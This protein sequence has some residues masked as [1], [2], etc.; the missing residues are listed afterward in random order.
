MSIIEKEIKRLIREAI[1]LDLAK[2]SLGI[3][4][5]VKQNLLKSLEDYE[6]LNKA[7]I[8]EEMAQQTNVPT[9]IPDDPEFHAAL[10]NTPGM[11]LSKEG[12]HATINRRQKPEQGGERTVRSGIFYLPGEENKIYTGKLGYGGTEKIIG[13]T[14]IKNPIVGRGGIGGSQFRKNVY[15]KIHG[16]GSW[17]REE[18]HVK[19]LFWRSPHN[20]DRKEELM[21]YLH[22]RHGIDRE[23]YKNIEENSSSGT[24]QKFTAILDTMVGNAAKRAGHDA[25]I[26]H[27]KGKIREIYDLRESTY[28]IHGHSGTM[29]EQYTKSEMADLNKSMNEAERIGTQIGIDWDKAEFT[30]Q[31]LAD[32]MKV[33]LEHGSKDPQ[34]NITDDDPI[35]TAKVALAHL[36]ENKDYYQKL[37]QVESDQTTA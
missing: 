34:T 3:K 23:Q 24:N 31:D 16:E 2:S 13:H 4:E 25:I 5:Y 33:E 19:L 26:T 17:D 22:H 37:K 20:P 35:K 14:L 10:Q 21:D 12:I 6:A 9:N 28:P 8:T 36:K 29:F 15:D 30:S 1:D 11:H 32:G 27:N 7:P 18:D